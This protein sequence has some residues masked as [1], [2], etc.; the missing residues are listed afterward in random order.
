MLCMAEG[1]R[2]CVSCSETLWAKCSVGDTVFLVLEQHTLHSL[3]AASLTVPSCTSL[4]HPRVAVGCLLQ[5]PGLQSSDTKYPTADNPG[6]AAGGSAFCIL[7]TA[8]AVFYLLDPSKRKYK[9]HC[10]GI[11]QLTPHKGCLRTRHSLDLTW[12]F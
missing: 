9:R 5:P 8:G 7:R 12:S 10:D 3:F 2:C 1:V 6:F 11:A 4:A